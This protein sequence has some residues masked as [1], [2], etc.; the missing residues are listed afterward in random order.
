M[1]REKFIEKLETSTSMD[2][3]EKEDT[4]DLE[5]NLASHKSFRGETNLII[6][7]EELAELQQCVTKF[8]RG[9]GDKINTIEEMADVLIGMEVIKNIMQ[10]DQEDVEKAIRVK[11]DRFIEN[12]KKQEE[13]NPYQ[14]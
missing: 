14:E 4:V 12:A 9:K 13:I 10:I 6:V 11:L 3:Q 2:A 5:I 1:D 8:I 7:T